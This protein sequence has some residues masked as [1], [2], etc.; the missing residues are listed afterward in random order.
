MLTREENERLIRAAKGTPGGEL[1]RRYW[2]PVALEEELPPGAPPR[3]VRVMGEDLVLFRDGSGRVGLMG[4]HCS[5]RKADL[6]YGRVEKDG[7]RCVYHGWLYGVDGRCLQQPGEPAGSSLKDEIRHLAYPCREVP[8]LI[9]AYLGPGEPPALPPFPFYSAPRDHVWTKKFYHECNYLQGNEG[10]IDPQHLSFL[11]RVET[12]S[13]AGRADLLEADVAPTIVVTETAWGLRIDTVRETGPDERYVRTGNFI[14]P[15]LA[16]FVGG[17][18]VPPNVEPPEA[19][20]GFSINWHVPIDDGTHWKFAIAYRSTGPVD[21]ALQE[22][23]TCQGLD[24][25]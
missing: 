18:L 20:T 7:L 24:A 2:Q 8:G 16:S 25:G 4:L 19:N 22:R 6:S 13:S 9:L 17:P 12:G 1:L 15:N 21:A 14:M 3:P 5:H 10:N 11:H 23:M